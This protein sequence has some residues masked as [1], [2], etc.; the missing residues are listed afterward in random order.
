MYYY[1]LIM[2][3]TYESCLQLDVVKQKNSDGV[4]VS[5]LFGSVL[6]SLAWFSYGYLLNDINIYVSE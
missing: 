3:E 5:L 4:P 6:C 2:N 1:W